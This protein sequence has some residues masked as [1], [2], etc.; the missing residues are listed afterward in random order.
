MSYGR[1]M[2]ALGKGNMN[3]DG[4][5]DACVDANV[6]YAFVEQDDCNGEDPFDCLKTSFEFLKA[7]GFN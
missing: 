7:R 6:E 1:K 2:A 5:L 4:I 3:F